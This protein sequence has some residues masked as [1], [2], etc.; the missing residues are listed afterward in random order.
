MTLHEAARYTRRDDVAVEVFPEAVLAFQ[1]MDCRLLQ[2]NATAIRL[3]NLLDGSRTVGDASRILAVEYGLPE[4]TA[5]KDVS[6][7]VTVL[8]RQRL[9]KPLAATDPRERNKGM[10]TVPSYLANPDVLCRI[11]DE[12]GA[13]LYN[14]D[15]DAVQVVNPVGLEI[16]QTLSVPR[17]S[18]EII[19]HLQS[20]C[21]GVPA[22]QVAKDVGDFLQTLLAAGFVGEMEVGNG[23]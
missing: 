15:T 23:C 12:S 16:W 5:L 21:E 11:E 9:L 19:T 7:A 3:L 8:E 13:I 2:L 10:S 22:E 18:D 17:K 14:P 4:E 20:V 6:E 1:A